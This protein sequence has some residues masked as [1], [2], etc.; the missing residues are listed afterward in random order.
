MRGAA[1]AALILLGGST[2]ASL[3]AEEPAVQAAPASP[4]PRGIV[5]EPRR[6][7]FAGPAL[8]AETKRIAGLLRCPVCQGLSVADSPVGMAVD[9]RTQV[10]DLV[11]AGYDEEQVLT[12]FEKSY[13]EFVRLEPP[14]RGVN[15]LVW[16]GP[17]AAML[18]GLA[19]VARLLRPSAVPPAD[20]PA[21]PDALPEDPELEPYVLRV[22]ELAYGWPDGRPPGPAPGEAEP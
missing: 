13:G 12:Y 18:A 2:L 14:L 4:D 20:P 7:A 21:A 3:S 17:L 11:A 9:M 1:V 5:G 16:A 15:W 19:L 8:E 10:R 6:G 22:R